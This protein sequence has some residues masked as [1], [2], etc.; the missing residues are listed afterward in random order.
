MPSVRSKVGIVPW[1]YA[2]RPE[3]PSQP[4][5]SGNAGGGATWAHGP[6]SITLG[7]GDDDR[8]FDPAA[9]GR[10]IGTMATDNPGYSSSA[11]SCRRVMIASASRPPLR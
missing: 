11:L 7:N 2:S 10:S 1:E 5:Q 3:N 4:I 6:D 8:R 9:H